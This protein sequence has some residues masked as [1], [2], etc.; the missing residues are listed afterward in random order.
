MEN[1]R[2]VLWVILL[3]SLLMLWDNWQRYN[4]KP[5]LLGIPSSQTASQNGAAAGAGAAAGSSA[6]ASNGA[7]PAA[8]A[9]VA[10]KAEVPAGQ[11]GAAAGK[12]IVVATDVL[13]LDIDTLGGEV[14]RAELLKHRD[15]ENEAANLVL[16]DSSSDRTYL[17]Q[18]G[19]TGAAGGAPAFPTHLSAWSVADGKDGDRVLA[20]GADT[21]S[22]ALTSE[23]GGIKVTKT[24][25]LKRGSYVI[26][27]KH[28]V[29]NTGSAPVAPTVYLQLVR[30]S[31]KVKGES[32]MF[33][34]G[35][36]TGPTIYTDKDKYQKIDFADI[37]KGK[38]SHATKAND[39]W[40]GMVQHYFVSAFIPVQDS[41][42]EY[43]TSKTPEG[44]YAVGTMQG[45]G[46]LQPGAKA[47][48]EA[49]LFIGPQDQDLLK[50]LAP[51][52]ELVVDFGW[53]KM[54]ADPLNA[55][56]RFFHGYVN[57][58]GWAIVL[59]TITVKLL[60]FPLSAASYKSMAKMKKVAPRM[61]QMKER[62]GNDK[63][64]LQRAMM[65]MYK[66]EKINP[67]GGCLPIVVQIPVFIALYWVLLASVEMRNAPW[68]LWIKDLAAPDPFY[69][70]PAIMAG[71]MLLQTWLNPPAADPV[72]Q[73]VMWAMPVVFGIT[74]F[75]FPAGLVL[76]WVV[77]NLL[78]IAQQWQINRM[79]EKGEGE[80]KA[81]AA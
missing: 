72:Q 52:L 70:L 68:I 8:S 25:E 41:P 47:T 65:D 50:Q 80:A 79:I 42:R 51:G 10:G 35:T 15:N 74:F 23:A 48:H 67:L 62:F 19:L 45:V 78:S 55:L 39:G 16:L 49:T 27:L 4:G 32:E 24:Y 38:T 18:S 54:L 37:D 76:Y 20:D 31:G 71:S 58:W 81:K 7:V 59:L 53:L 36:F 75:F 60:F 17:A 3:V 11:A 34:T 64:G 26:K 61:Q 1:Q 2:T 73:K 66:T 5:S 9:A 69:I 21:L 28:E 6:G 30:D 29:E 63:E 44:R 40:I 57:N 14:K 22:F 56:L 13:K 12:R 46:S 77:N 33:G 43:F